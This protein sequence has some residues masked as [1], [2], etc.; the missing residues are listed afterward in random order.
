MFAHT[1][2]CRVIEY[3]ASG[4]QNSHHL[5]YTYMYVFLWK[6]SSQQ[7]LKVKSIPAYGQV[8]SSDVTFSS[9]L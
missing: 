7:S 5:T 2:A 1:K 8:S 4:V 9:E 6:L 3:F